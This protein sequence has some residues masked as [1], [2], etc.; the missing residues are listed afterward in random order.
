LTHGFCTQK[1]AASKRI[2]VSA[3]DEHN[4]PSPP[5]PVPRD[6]FQIHELTGEICQDGALPSP[7]R[8]WS[9]LDD[10]SHAKEEPSEK[11]PISPTRRTMKV[12]KV[13]INLSINSH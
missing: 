12:A 5:T 7:V 8:D 11:T 3:Q 9:W 6:Q 13:G 4:S 1:A 10:D 2:E